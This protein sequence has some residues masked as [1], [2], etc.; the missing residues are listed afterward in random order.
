MHALAY[1]LYFSAQHKDLN[2]GSV[3]K[4]YS[5]LRP[6]GEERAHTHEHIFG[7]LISQRHRV[8]AGITWILS[9]EVVHMRKAAWGKRLEQLAALKQRTG[10]ASVDARSHSE[11]LHDWLE[12]QKA[13]LAIGAPQWEFRSEIKKTP[14]SSRR[15][16]Q[17]CAL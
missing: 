7:G 14:S 2:G 3:S 15:A 11:S 8:C 4:F 17:R 13:L 9:D 16:L 1:L 12:H 5:F 6:S 10:A